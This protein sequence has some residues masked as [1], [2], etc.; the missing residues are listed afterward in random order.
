MH[1]DQIVSDVDVGHT[2]RPR[3]KSCSYGIACGC[4]VSSNVAGASCGVLLELSF[5]DVGGA[6]PRHN[7][8]CPCAAAHVTLRG[9]VHMAAVGAGRISRICMFL[10]S[11]FH[12][13]Q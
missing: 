10:H 8:D 7:F 6:F 5:L 9:A 11:N 12:S 4:I 13:L 3:V 1:P 2:T